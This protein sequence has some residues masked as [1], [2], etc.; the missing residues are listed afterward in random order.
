LRELFWFDAVHLRE[1]AHVHASRSPA[2]VLA[3]PAVS[4]KRVDA[5]MSAWVDGR[6]R[7]S[8][9]PIFD[10]SGDPRVAASVTLAGVLFVL[11]AGTVLALDL[12]LKLTPQFPTRISTAAAPT[13]APVRVVGTTPSAG[14]SCERQTWPYIDQ[15]CLVRT[16][17]K[18]RTDDTPAAAQ[19]SAKLSPMTATAP[20]VLGQS[21][22]QEGATGSAP[23]SESVQP[24][25]PREPITINAPMPSD[26][27]MTNADG[28]APQ[29]RIVEPAH[30]TRANRN[31]GFPYPIRFGGFR[32]F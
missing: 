18:P 7:L 21:A 24:S 2:P 25:A 15:R 10:H 22:Q 26:S 31:N 30:R 27:I 3:P 12:P 14:V 29:L 9:D 19:G 1:R 6:R 32:L 20:V 4:M 5:S 16:E 23:Q 17:A 28:D 13:S 11:I 8:L